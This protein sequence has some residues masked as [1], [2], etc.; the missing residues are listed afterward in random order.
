[1][2]DLFPVLNKRNNNKITS[3]CQNTN[4]QI[5][6]PGSGV[7]YLCLML[8]QHSSSY[9]MIFN[10]MRLNYCKHHTMLTDLR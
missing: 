9:L 4:T 1:M 2:L 7:V 5:N 8:P 10:S 3:V 6:V